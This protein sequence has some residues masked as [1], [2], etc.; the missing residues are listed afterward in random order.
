MRLRRKATTR[1]GD[2]KAQ[3]GDQPCDLYRDVDIDI[4]YGVGPV[5]EHLRPWH[6]S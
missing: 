6:W 1:T 2:P 5:Y 4:P 3:D